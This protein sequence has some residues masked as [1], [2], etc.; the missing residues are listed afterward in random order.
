M[1]KQVVV[2]VGA[3]PSGDGSIWETD[4]TT[5]GTFSIGLAGG[6][7]FASLVPPDFT[8]LGAN[9]IFTG[10]NAAG[11]V[12]LWI[13]DGTAAGTQEIVPSGAG[14]SGVRFAAYGQGGYAV[15]GNTAYFDGINAANYSG[16]WS[17]Q[18][19][20][21]TTTQV[22]VPNA[23]ATSLGPSELTAF[24]GG[25]KILFAGSPA[26]SYSYSLFLITS[27]GVGQV[28]AGGFS[29]NLSAGFAS[30]GNAVVF[31]A[32]DST[33]SAGALWVSDGTAAGTQRIGPPPD[34]FNLGIVP[35]DITSVGTIALFAATIAS[36]TLDRTDLWTTNGSTAGTQDLSASNPNANANGLLASDTPDFTRLSATQVLFSG[37]DA[38]GNYGLWSTDGTTAAS[39]HEITVAGA[40]AGGLFDPNG[41]VHMTQPRFAALNG[42]VLFY[43]LDAAGQQGL[44]IT[45]GTSA[46]THEITVANA[47]SYGVI[48]NDLTTVSVPCFATGTRIATARGEVA[49][50]ALAVGDLLRTRRGARPV[51]WIG[52]RQVDCRRHPTPTD[53]WPVCVRAGAFGRNRPARD[54]WL[55]PDHAVFVAGALIPVRYLVNG[56]SIAQEPRDTVT[57]WHVELERHGVLLAE[58]LPCE[59]YLD[60]GNRAAFANGGDAVQLHPAFAHAVWDTRACAPLVLDG[61]A[62]ATAR[63]RLLARAA[64]L[65]HATTQDPALRVLADGRE[66]PAVREG[67]TWHVAI[68]AGAERVRLLSRTWVP[69][70]MSEQ[71]DTRVLG[72]ALARLWLDGREAS[73]DSPGLGA[74]WHAAEARWRWTDGAGEI[75]PT[76]ARSLA[77]ELAMTGTYWA[78]EAPWAEHA[79]AWREAAG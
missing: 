21:A 34:S 53:V 66:V 72:V 41:P 67:N 73:L 3:G 27:S 16:L 68:P 29:P 58:G 75:D 65:G 43:G 42:K 47:S 14:P 50:E 40:Y 61:P 57:Y 64:K 56:R 45:D 60:T 7:P 9:V 23:S 70:R 69:A 31:D 24:A 4:G 36:P 59:S 18:G 6:A 33:D 1:T 48:P 71:S 63:R 55:S 44:W 13:T 28:Q 2:F 22:T 49:V 5:A 76:G 79:P 78:A 62:L 46:G 77:F 20:S 30:V 12:G 51:R 19:T 17:T 39:T 10:T 74:G 15:L 35:N 32:A 8:Q 54:L 11:Q 25:T 26:S 38:A 37:V 52:H